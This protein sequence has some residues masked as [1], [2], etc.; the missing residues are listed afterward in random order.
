MQ[1][2]NKNKMKSNI[3][4][5]ISLKTAIFLLFFL[6]FIP[7][8]SKA[9]LASNL[10]YPVDNWKI[11]QGG[12]E[13]GNVRKDSVYHL[14]ADIMKKA[15]E[16]VYSLM[17]GTVRHIGIHSRFGTVIL[18]EH[19]LNDEKVVSL[20]GHLR[21]IDVEVAEGQQ[22]KRGQ[23]IGH[24]G[25]AGAENGYWAEHLHFGIRKGA[26]VDTNVTWVYWGMGDEE[27]LS[28][29]Y[30][31]AVFL[32]TGGKVM[33]DLKQVSKIITSPGLGGNTQ[34]KLF[35]KKGQKIENSD[36]Y[37][38]NQNFD[39]GGDAAFG[40][41]DG[42]DNI[43]E[44]IVG[45]GKGNAP[46]VKI[47]RKK[48][49]ELLRKFLAYDESFTGGVRVTTGD[50]DGDGIDEIVTGA[51]PGGG[52]HIRV[53]DNLGNVIYAKLFPFGEEISGTGADVACGDIDG[54][55]RDEIIASLGP[56]HEPKIAIINEN[57]KTEKKFLAYDKYFRGG[58][59]V[60]TADVDRDGKDEIVTGAGPGGGPHVRVF[61][62]NG[63]PRGIDYF[64]FH[65]DFR[66]G[67]DVGAIDYDEDGKDEIIMTQNSQGQA[68]VK[69]YRY[70]DE[71]TVY[72]NFLA[73]PEYFE[74][75]AF[76]SGLK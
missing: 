66:G 12:G 17:N 40:K 57:G 14:G 11:V 9:E 43:A 2:Q 49:K 5:K 7:H 3:L 50:L 55:G 64:P 70:N 1:E 36:I 69:V 46:Y 29:W 52:A 45:A 24:I 27:E 19:T 73:Y 59:N 33:V 62:A 74:G 16:N 10:A 28:H 31:P 65:I 35:N 21:G 63:N 18:I 71:K 58:V 15:G 6:I 32:G 68:W 54:D 39:G 48:T 30:D 41:T 34:I 61:E 47:Y 76:V 37:A 67:V 72:A 75:G 42:K 51:G 38:S 25:A 60:A 13:F 8:E 56:G 4:L 22:V 44:L 20:Y 53:F 26:Y 23:L